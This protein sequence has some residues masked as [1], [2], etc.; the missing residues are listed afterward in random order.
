MSK[1]A[2]LPFACDVC[3]DPKGPAHG[4]W[5]VMLRVS[6]MDISGYAIYDWNDQL[7]TMADANHTC[8]DR[9]TQT[10]LERALALSAARKGIS[11]TA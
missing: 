6:V 4:R 5:R 7:A 9:C 10:L 2:A 8:G 11:V 3:N 1:S